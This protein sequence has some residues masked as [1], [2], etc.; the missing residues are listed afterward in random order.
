MNYNNHLDKIIPFQMFCTYLGVLIIEN[1]KFNMAKE[2]RMTEARKEIIVL[3][4]L[5]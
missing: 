3:K 5:L 4:Q 1:C 2:E